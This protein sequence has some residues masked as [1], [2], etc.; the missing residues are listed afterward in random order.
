MCAPVRSKS[1][2]LVVR[3][4]DLTV[5]V[6]SWASGAPIDFMGYRWM[7]DPTVVNAWGQWFARFHAISRRFSGAFPDVAARIQ[8]W[9]QVLRISAVL[10]EGVPLIICTMSLSRL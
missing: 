1:G 2:E 5:V 6:Y 3:S 10:F 9:D 7:T 4:G 8:R